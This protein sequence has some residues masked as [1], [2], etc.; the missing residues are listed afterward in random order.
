MQQ[1]RIKKCKQLVDD[2][3]NSIREAEKAQEKS[4]RIGRIISGVITALGVAA[5][6]FSGGLSMVAAGIS[7]AVFVTDCVLADMDIMTASEALMIPVQKGLIE[8]LSKALVECMVVTAK[9]YGKDINREDAEIA[10]GVLATAF[11]F[12][13]TMAV[14]V[15][16]ANKLATTNV[17]GETFRRVMNYSLSGMNPNTLRIVLGAAQTTIQLSSSAFQTYSDVQIAKSQTAEKNAEGDMTLMNAEM[18]I[19]KAIIQQCV[20][21][22]CKADTSYELMKKVSNILSEL[23]ASGS[24]VARNIAA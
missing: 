24:Q 20:D 23:N 18:A 16:G 2:Y 6:P 4:S 3:Q 17:L 1:D 8:P 22:F 19:L 13:G 7:V 12:A 15:Y 21:H 5:A 14:G 9:Q 11:V 10:A